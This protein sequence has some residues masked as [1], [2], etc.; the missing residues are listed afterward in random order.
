MVGLCKE[1]KYE[2]VIGPSNK[3]TKKPS[4]GV[5]CISKE[6]KAKLVITEHIT[7]AFKNAYEMGRVEKYLLDL[8]WDRMVQV[9][10]IYGQSGAGK[11][12]IAVTEAIIEAVRE[13]RDQEPHLP[14]LI[15]GDVNA[16]PS[17]LRNLKDLVA[18][19]WVDLGL[20]AD[21]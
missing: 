15:V 3:D 14:T 21:W 5:G 9:F 18:E 12:D 6:D 17:K 13:E 20:N 10:N 1:E 4:A 2:A 8:G 7:E 11:E 16:D 19:G